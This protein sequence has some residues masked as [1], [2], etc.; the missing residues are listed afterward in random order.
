M[1]ML[2]PLL[3]C[4]KDFVG[5][6]KPFYI[7]ARCVRGS[8]HGSPCPRTPGPNALPAAEI[9]LLLPGCTAVTR[10]DLACRLGMILW[11]EVVF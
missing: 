2:P 9:V 4:A 7:V 3:F 11:M 1:P 5:H 6:C 8:N 10:M